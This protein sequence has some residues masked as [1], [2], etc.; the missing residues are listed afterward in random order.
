MPPPSKIDSQQL[1]PTERPLEL[2]SFEG[3]QNIIDLP[4][5]RLAF[6]IMLEGTLAGSLRGCSAT[7][8]SGWSLARAELDEA[9]EQCHRYLRRDTEGSRGPRLAQSFCICQSTNPLI[10]NRRQA[11]L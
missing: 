2:V 8:I 3:R 6:A 11:G 1:D 4:L 5:Y 7:P 10:R 9:L